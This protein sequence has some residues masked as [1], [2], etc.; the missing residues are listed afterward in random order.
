LD[1]AFLALGSPLDFLTRGLYSR[2]PLEA[3]R[4]M[5]H[6][7]TKSKKLVLDVINKRMES[8][9][10]NS[11][12]DQD[13]LDLILDASNST[14][15]NSRL[16]P[17]EILHDMFMF[18]LAGHETSA[19][20]LT[21]A[22]Y[23]LGKDP[24]LQEQLYETV[25]KAVGKTNQVNSEN[26]KD[27]ALVRSVLKE[28][29]RFQP[30]IVTVGQRVA[31]RDTELAGYRIPKGTRVICSLVKAHFSEKFWDK[32]REFIPTRFMNE[33]DPH[34]LFSFSAGPRICIGHKFSITE[35]T[36]ALAMLVREFKWTLKPGYVW[37]DDTYALTTS[38]RGGMPINLEK[39]L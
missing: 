20:T 1:A 35:M 25:I 13:L 2:L 8:R 3:V 14:D 9:K 22:M 36:I 31:L 32:P 6:G 7:I 30:P 11:A 5:K 10:Q 17:R 4:K 19:G 12:H 24:S 16:S 23:F 18:F 27:L 33:D 38:P 28:T 29:L 37:R 15:T 26:I 21:S 34:Q 39:R